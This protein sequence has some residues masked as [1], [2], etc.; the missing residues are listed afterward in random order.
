MIRTSSIIQAAAV[1]AVLLAGGCVHVEIFHP[2]MEG[3]YHFGP[4][5]PFWAYEGQ[6]RHVAL[7]RPVVP[8]AQEAGTW[9][10]AASCQMLLESQGVSLSQPEIVRRAYG[11]VRE[12]GGKS[13]LMVQILTGEF[14]G[15]QGAKVR[16]E[17]HRADGLPHNGFELVDSIEN[18]IPF[19]LDIGYYKEGKAKRGAAY[20][21]HSVLVEGV[22]YQRE[23]NEIRLLSLD[24]IDPS[25]AMIQRTEPDYAPRQVLEAKDFD[26]IQGTLGV[27]RK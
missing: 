17:A 20:A 25:Y 22:T 21:A 3:T 8:R 13:P 9:C 14:T 27:Y 19:I 10:W 18:G 23:G 15:S 7:A 1:C 6:V 12:A 2:D 11:E 24:T 4:D 26:A 16:L 5:R